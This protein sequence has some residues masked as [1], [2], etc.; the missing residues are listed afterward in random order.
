MTENC[1]FLI[2]EWAARGG[3][4]GG[5]GEGLS[6]VLFSLPGSLESNFTALLAFT[7]LEKSNNN[8]IV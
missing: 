2:R 1:I 4:G 8:A 3:G 6:M 7:A 5:A